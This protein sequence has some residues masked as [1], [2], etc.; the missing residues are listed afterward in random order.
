MPVLLQKIITKLY[1]LYFNIFVWFVPNKIAHQAFEVFCTVRK[2]KVLPNQKQ[3]LDD[4]KL[5]VI[6]VAEH[7]IQLYG[8]PG[9]KETVLLV[10]G[11]ESNT[12]RWHK[13]I[14]KLQ[15]A[16]YNIIAFDA[17]AHGYSTG[18][19]WY[20]PLYA[21]ALQ[22]II[23]KYQPKTV[24]GHSVGGMTALY[25]EHKNPNVF[26]EKIVTVSSP[27]EFHEILTHY[28]NLLGFSNKVM[29]A[30][31]EYYY[32]RFGFTPKEFSSSR[33]VLTNS[34]KGLLFHDRLDKI[35]PYHASVDVHKHWKGS[36]LVSTE[37][38]GHS[39]HQNEVNDKIIAFLEEQ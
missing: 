17:P 27:S 11:W 10:H 31:E 16:N 19:L 25:N 12:W 1:G 33:F 36:E 20:A 8:W 30:L 13:L 7:S 38:F 14:E 32:S 26:I 15:K 3:Y 21:E 6:N 9:N 35:T 4:A 18:K 34:K 5:D 22:A 37:G 24:V 2:G 29:T 28:K 39:M 23:L